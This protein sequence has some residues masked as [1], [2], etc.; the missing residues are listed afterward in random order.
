MFNRNRTLFIEAIL[1]DDILQYNITKQCVQFNLPNLFKKCFPGVNIE[2]LDFE[3]ATTLVQKE[4]LKTGKNDL[5]RIKDTDEL[6]FRANKPAWVFSVLF[7]GDLVLDWNY[8]AIIPLE[9]LHRENSWTFPV[10]S[11]T[12]FL[13]LIER[14]VRTQQI[15][16]TLSQFD[17]VL[18]YVTRGE[19]GND[20]DCKKPNM[21]KSDPQPHESTCGSSL[22]ANGISGSERI[23]G[24]PLFGGSRPFNSRRVVLD[25]HT[26]SD[27]FKIRGQMS[28]N[29]NKPEAKPESKISYGIQFYICQPY[30]GKYSK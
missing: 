9:S 27:E 4:L 20:F 8:P 14:H 3:T 21:F 16:D 6:Y 30:Q 25:K 15:T 2:L 5:Y 23:S 13:R 12:S 28:S 19:L 17:I 1:L 22:F 10:L 24:S 26:D 29:Q 11:V 18:R 7:G